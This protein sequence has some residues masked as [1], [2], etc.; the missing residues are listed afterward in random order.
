MQQLSQKRLTNTPTDILSSYRLPRYSGAVHI[1]SNCGLSLNSPED[2]NGAAGPTSLC[3][4]SDAALNPKG[5]NMQIYVLNHKCKP[6][7]PCSN[8]HTHY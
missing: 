7:M 2:R 3:N 1:Y 5:E 8:G 6:L 4:N